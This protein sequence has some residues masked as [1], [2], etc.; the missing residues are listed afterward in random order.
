[1][2]V[3]LNNNYDDLDVGTKLYIID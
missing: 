3:A 2:W 1:L